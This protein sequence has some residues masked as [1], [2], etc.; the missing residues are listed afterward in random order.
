MSKRDEFVTR[1][2]TW[3]VKP[4]GYKYMSSFMDDD[5]DMC[6]RRHEEMMK[7]PYWNGY[8]FIHVPIA[9]QVPDEAVDKII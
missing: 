3:V 5:K 9:I 7:D 4:D 6:D 2:I 1:W 8:K